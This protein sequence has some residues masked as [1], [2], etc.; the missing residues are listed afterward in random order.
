MHRSKINTLG[1]EEPVAM[2]IKVRSSI[3]LAIIPAIIEEQYLTVIDDI[4]NE[5]TG[6]CIGIIDQI[7][8]HEWR[9]NV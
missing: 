5:K 2:K 4:V 8:N 7:L 6:S 3:F 1:G 9:T